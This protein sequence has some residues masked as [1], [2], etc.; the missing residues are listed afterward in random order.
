MTDLAS[1]YRDKS[2]SF[3]TKA[4]LASVHVGIVLLVLWVLFGGGIARIDA[5]VGVEPRLASV[6]RRTG[7][8][9]AAFLYFFRTLFTV[10]LFVRRRM[11]WSEAA[12][13]AVWIAA[14]DVLRAYVGGRND[15]LP[16]T[17]FLLGD[18]LLV[19]PALMPGGFGF[20]DIPA[21]D[22]YLAERYGDEYR[23]YARRTPRLIPF[24]Y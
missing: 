22:R 8:A 14:I 10:F 5:L 2:P 16:G 20:V 3:D 18:A 15:A 7:L 21:Q 4:T 9:A 12:T 13:I 23:D 6:S 11:P 19:I 17:V 24:I 1:V